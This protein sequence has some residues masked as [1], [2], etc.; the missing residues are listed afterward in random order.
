MTDLI[1]DA[2]VVAKWLVA[3]RDSPKA[4]ELISPD[5]YLRAPDLVIPEVLNILWKKKVR[6]D[7]NLRAN[8]IVVDAET[9]AFPDGRGAQR[10]GVR[11]RV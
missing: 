3:E 7:L 1:V 8:W 5:I 2:S 4:R 9:G 10:R 6:G 11:N